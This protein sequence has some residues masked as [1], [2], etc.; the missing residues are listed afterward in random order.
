MTR[1][2]EQEPA[3]EP[4]PRPDPLRI[5][6]SHVRPYR[7]R[8]AS[9][10]T[11]LLITNA[12]GASIP[13]LIKRIIER[14]EAG[15][16][17]APIAASIVAV[18]A[19]MAG[20]RTGSRIFILGT[21]RRV[22]ADIRETLYGHIQSLSRSF[23]DRAR[24][25]DLLS[26]VTSDV[27]LMRG[28]TGFGLMNV[29]NTAAALAFS[30]AMMLRID[31]GLTVSAFLPYLLL[32]GVVRQV[33]RRVHLRTFD[34]QRKLAD[35]T[36]LATERLSGFSVVR[37]LGAEAETVTRF[38][39]SNDAYLRAHLD[40]V[41]ARGAM[42]PLFT[43]MGGVGALVVLWLGGRKV[44]TGALSLGDFV[45]AT[46]YLAM[47]AW[48]TMAVGWILNLIQRARAAAGRFDEILRT[49]PEVVD[50]AAGARSQPAGPAPGGAA[51]LL[52]VRDLSFSFGSG[53]AE[54]P[55]LR[56]VSFDLPAGSILGITG[57]V[58]SGKSTLLALLCREYPPSGGSILFAGTE[59]EKLPL[60]ELRRRI[61]AVPQQAFLFQRSVRDN[62]GFGRDE[63][64]G[65]RRL[66]EVS[67]LSGL[68]SIASEL[69][70]GFE[71]SAGE[72][73]GALSGGQ[74]QRVALA[75]ALACD[76]ELLIL[77]DPFS[78]VDAATEDEVLQRLATHLRG[79]SAILVSHRSTSLI[80]ADSILVMEAGRIAEAGDH[81]S[82]LAAG[83]LYA[84]LHARSL[85][86]RALEESA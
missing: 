5:V 30:I 48:P 67:A 58:G 21:S 17:V 45:A 84:R 46:G 76:A 31:P 26:R 51:P 38:G 80:F 43:A 32:I 82:L 42:V 56:G 4:A 18:A 39:M 59:I 66:A 70:R 64:I 72:R 53:G 10:L 49:R 52:A 61:A 23:F 9:G 37:T 24:S 83:G 28:L 33:T 35:L 71:T 34:A 15:Q 69:G 73:G 78:A 14:L 16:T 44:A 54:Q 79:R 81:Q 47:A 8:Y 7:L 41:R 65:E 11:L 20:V 25:G 36:A 86:E 55:L 40:L 2:P 13:W 62:I 29:M 63:P 57:P 68:A 6:L 75:R 1:E 77:D 3:P 50:V 19:L 12:L 22:S 60:A 85:L 74:R 27:Q